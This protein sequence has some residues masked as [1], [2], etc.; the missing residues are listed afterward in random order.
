[1]IRWTFPALAI[2]IA[3]LVAFPLTADAQMQVGK[4]RP[5]WDTVANWMEARR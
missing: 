4:P 1:M 2:C 5:S 3:T